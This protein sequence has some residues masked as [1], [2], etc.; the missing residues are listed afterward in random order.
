M[1]FLNL[2]EVTISA[3][4]KNAHYEFP[5]SK[6]LRTALASVFTDY[7]TKA[8][9][10]AGF[11]ARGLLVTGISRVGKSR[12]IR[13]AVTQFN[14][15]AIMMP[16]GR[17]AHIIQCNLS[18]RVSWKDLGIKTLGALGYN[19]KA[20]RTQTYIWQLVLE[21]AQRQ[22][23]VGMHFDECQ[24][25]FTG[26]GETINEKML[27]SFKTLLKDSSWPL[28]L[29]LSGVP[30]LAKYVG[31]YVQL[32]ELLDP[33]HF[34]PIDITKDED[35][36]ELN[37]LAY[38]FADKVGLNFDPLSNRDFF[39]RLAFT[40]DNRWGLVIELI[41]AAFTK[42]KMSGSTTLDVKHFVEVFAKKR[43]LP[44]DFSPFTAPDYKSLFDQAT[45]NAILNRA[46]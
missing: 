8:T 25:V 21:Q 11:E 38:T 27:D 14:D 34:A 46:D 20:N 45:L 36:T 32:R 23:V 33:V 17:P 24:H 4:L 12:E 40:C 37:R 44:M 2:H 26:N 6:V 35:I 7:Y 3:P 39:E 42:C 43:G 30:E 9:S 31:P 5:R 10:G 29:I 41:T 18:G 15:A 16:D 28:M 13:R 19:L 1:T 22:G